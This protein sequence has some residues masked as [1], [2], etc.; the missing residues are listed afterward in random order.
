L[1]CHVELD[2]ICYGDYSKGV[3]FV[4]TFVVHAT[5]GGHGFRPD[6]SVGLSRPR[7]NPNLFGYRKLYSFAS[8]Q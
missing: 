6:V 7:L 3:V 4:L 2:W 5:N 1:Y 8:F